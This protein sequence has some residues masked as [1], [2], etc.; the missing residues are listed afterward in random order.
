[1]KISIA[2]RY[3]HGFRTRKAKISAASK[4]IIFLSSGMSACTHKII[5][6]RNIRNTKMAK[7]LKTYFMPMK[8]QIIWFCDHNL[9]TAKLPD[10]EKGY[11]YLPE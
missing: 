11:L 9:S 3:V 8:V 10:L 7:A 5:L 6:E 2:R 4:S 1:M